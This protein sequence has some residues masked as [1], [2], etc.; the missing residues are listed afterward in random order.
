MARTDW[1]FSF[2]M[3]Y[4]MKFKAAIRGHHVFKAT[5]SSLMREVLFCK[6]GN[7]KEAKKYDSNAVR[8]Y[9][10]IAE[11]VTIF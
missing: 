4:E 1:N 3:S 2:S 11:S 10:D 8:A 9:K 6:K 5:W 7:R